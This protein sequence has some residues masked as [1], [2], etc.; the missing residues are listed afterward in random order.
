VEL[1][2]GGRTVEITEMILRNAGIRVIRRRP[3]GF[4]AVV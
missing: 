3:A 4:S 2:I 1:D